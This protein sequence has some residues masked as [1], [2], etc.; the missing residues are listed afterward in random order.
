MHTEDKSSARVDY[1]EWGGYSRIRDVCFE[2]RICWEF[3]RDLFIEG[4]LIKSFKAVAGQLSGSR[5]AAF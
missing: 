5:G 3:S 2:K 4:R 1:T